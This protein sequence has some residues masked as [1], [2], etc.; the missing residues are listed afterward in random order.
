MSLKRWSGGHICSPIL[1]CHRDPCEA[2]SVR[3]LHLCEFSAVYRISAKVRG[4]VGPQFRVARL[5]GRS[6]HLLVRVL[7]LGCEY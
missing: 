1:C 5:D 3:E 2:E 4:H 6:A 7:I